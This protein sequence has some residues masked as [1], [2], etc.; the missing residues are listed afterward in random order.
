MN[1]NVIFLSV[2]KPGDGKEDNSG[3]IVIRHASTKYTIKVHAE[4]VLGS[5]SERLSGVLHVLKEDIILI[6]RGIKYNYECDTKLSS[7]LNSNGRAQFVLQLSNSHWL[8]R[9]I[10]A[11]IRKEQETVDSYIS[12]IPKRRKQLKLD[13]SS[14]HVRLGEIKADLML[15]AGSA[16]QF[17]AAS[18]EMD[19]LKRTLQKATKMLNE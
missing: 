5:I 9:D 17:C 1:E 8:N 19:T 18:A 14:N 11:W 12:E 2:S 15:I 7:L 16:D 10:S 3:E 13:Y 6:H 4:C